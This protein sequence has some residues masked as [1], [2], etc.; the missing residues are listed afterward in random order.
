MQRRKSKN[1][2]KE[3]DK[4]NKNDITTVEKYQYFNN[5]NSY[6]K[7]VIMKNKHAMFTDIAIP[8]DKNVIKIEAETILKYKNL[9]TEKEHM[10]NVTTK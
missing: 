10:C 4:Q 3:T 9:I 7:S 5:N 1:T 2:Q 6:N 8:G